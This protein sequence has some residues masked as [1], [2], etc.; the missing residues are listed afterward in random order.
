MVVKISRTDK[1]AFAR[2]GIGGGVSGGGIVY[3]AKIVS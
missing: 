2:E 1:Y 3:R